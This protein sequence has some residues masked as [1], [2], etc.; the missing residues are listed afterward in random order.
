MAAQ[1]FVVADPGVTGAT[2]ASDGSLSR[3]TT[4]WLNL[5]GERTFSVPGAC[6]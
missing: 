6:L 3:S 2:P 4:G 1:R 5:G